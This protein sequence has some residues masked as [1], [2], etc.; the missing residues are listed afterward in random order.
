M[1]Y[2]GYTTIYRVNETEKRIDIVRMFHKNKP[3]LKN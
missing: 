3:P 2:K 1:I